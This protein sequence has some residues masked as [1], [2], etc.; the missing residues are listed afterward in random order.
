MSSAGPTFSVLGPDITITGDLT[1]SAD[2]HVDG[3]VQGDISCVALV[4]GELSEITG[5]VVAE[6]ARVAG[7]IKGSISASVLVI[8]KS[9]RI[10][11]DVTYEALTIEQ[12]AQVDG[13][14][15]HR[16]AE[17]K[18][19]LAGGTAASATESGTQYVIRKPAEAAG[20]PA[21]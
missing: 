19:T 15:A 1:A 6:S 4:Q 10:E 5:I 8:L 21:Q 14:F 9:A 7:R 20:L 2:L 13:K 16:S 12:G 17:P 18:L 3:K 11:G